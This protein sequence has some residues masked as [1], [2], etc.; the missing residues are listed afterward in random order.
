LHL[1]QAIYQPCFGYIT[2]IALQK[3]YYYYNSAE[4]PLKE[5]TGVFTTITGLPCAHT[6]NDRRAAGLV[7]QPADFH[8]HW[9]WDRY[10]VITLPIL[11]PLQIISRT[12]TTTTSTRRLPSGFEASEPQVRLCS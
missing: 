9:H 12:R 7:L 1:D 6:I 4:K 5:C 11:E 10:S 3:A 8:L 2:V